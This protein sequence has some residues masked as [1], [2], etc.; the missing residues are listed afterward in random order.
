MALEGLRSQPVAP[1]GVCGGW[2]GRDRLASQELVL[3]VP[4]APQD[5]C[6]PRADAPPGPTHGCLA[7]SWGLGG[8]E[9]SSRRFR[10]C[11]PLSGR[12]GTPVMLLTADS[13]TSNASTTNLAFAQLLTLGMQ[14]AF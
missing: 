6:S 12:D 9:P 2:D 1:S 7:L 4:G 3:R 5:E 10:S 14:S 13:S 8:A 11:M